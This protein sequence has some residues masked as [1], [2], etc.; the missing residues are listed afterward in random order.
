MPME[1]RGEVYARQQAGAAI[2]N[3]LLSIENHGLSTCWV[4]Y[5]SEYQIK[6]ELEIPDEINVEAVFPIGFEFETKLT[7]K[8]KIDIDDILYFNH[9]GQNKMK[10]ERKIEA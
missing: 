2:E 1:N 3:F 9:Y 10:K 7:R 8:A 5:F 6:R 4:G